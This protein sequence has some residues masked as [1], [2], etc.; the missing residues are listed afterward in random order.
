MNWRFGG[1]EGI[2]GVS[3]G[4]QETPPGLISFP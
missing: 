1:G 2:G 4:E 3:G